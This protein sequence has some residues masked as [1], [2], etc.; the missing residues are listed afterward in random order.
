M[1]EVITTLHK[2]GDNTVDVYPNI[3]SENIPNDAVSEDKILDGAVTTDKIADDSV[4]EDKILDGSVTTDKIA[5]SSVTLD[6]LGFDLYFTSFMMIFDS[7]AVTLSF[8]TKTLIDSTNIADFIKYIFDDV[9]RVHMFTVYTAV[10][11][12][13][14]KT[15]TINTLILPPDGKGIALYDDLDN[16]VAYIALNDITSANFGNIVSKPIY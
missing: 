3:K 4:T 1:S 11:T 16:E 15:G 12:I 6:K 2:K 10:G 13:E 5:D 8:T 14:Y 9:N 7:H